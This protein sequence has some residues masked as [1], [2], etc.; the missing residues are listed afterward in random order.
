MLDITFKIRCNSQKKKS[1]SI[2][3]K[4][5]SIIFFK[6]NNSKLL[7]LRSQVTYRIHKISTTVKYIYNSN[8]NNNFSNSHWNL[9]KI[10]KYQINYNNHSTKISDISNKFK[11]FT[12]PVTSLFILMMSGYKI[13]HIKI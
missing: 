13:L 12:F 10:N 11:M 6:N 1:G 3:Q 8:N 9:H 4:N 2:K 7:H 5:G